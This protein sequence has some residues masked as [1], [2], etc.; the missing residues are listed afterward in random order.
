MILI[1]QAVCHRSSWWL[2][3]SW[4]NYLW[5]HSNFCYLTLQGQEIDNKM[6]SK[7]AREGAH[8]FPQVISARILRDFYPTPFQGSS[9]K[10]KYI[11][12]HFC[13]L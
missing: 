4:L 13:I 10:R 2:C 8:S 7:S 3:S 5:N 12:V 1:P 9:Q 6:Y 11:L